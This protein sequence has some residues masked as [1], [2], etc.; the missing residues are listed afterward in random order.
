MP[1][2]AIDKKDKEARGLPWKM[3]LTVREKE[4]KEDEAD[5]NH[6]GP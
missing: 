6:Y 1:L 5:K 2:T 3:S 4:D